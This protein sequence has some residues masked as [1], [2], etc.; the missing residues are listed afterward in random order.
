MQTL[1][2]KIHEWY[3]FKNTPGEIKPTPPSIFS[4]I[5][6]FRSFM[7]DLC[8]VSQ[9]S[10]VDK[11]GPSWYSVYLPDKAQDLPALP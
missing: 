5:L 7:L 8:F 9:F 3:V 2:V 4:C 6:F 10:T 1:R 11:A